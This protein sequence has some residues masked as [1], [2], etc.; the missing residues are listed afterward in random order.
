MKATSPRSKK[1]QAASEAAPRICSECPNP[2]TSKHSLCKTCSAACSRAR[3]KRLGKEARTRFNIRVSTRYGWESF[4]LCVEC[5]LPIPIWRQPHAITCSN[6][7]LRDRSESKAKQSGQKRPKPAVPYQRSLP[8]LCDLILLALREP[9]ACFEL[10]P[11]HSSYESLSTKVD[12]LYYAGYIGREFVQDWYAKIPSQRGYYRYF[13]TDMGWDRCEDGL[14]RHPEL[15]AA[16]DRLSP[17]RKITPPPPLEQ[18]KDDS[19]PEDI[20]GDD[21]G[22]EWAA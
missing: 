6:K 21:D 12:N 9:R 18:D 14:V 22:F 3:E 11:L 5:A 10:R 17:P 8:T 2:I 13:L 15:Q 1:R 7:C 19:V 4:R 20:Y 16:L